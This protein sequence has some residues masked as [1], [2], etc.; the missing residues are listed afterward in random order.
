[1][2]LNE[3]IKDRV[4]AILA[5]R[6]QKARV[7]AQHRWEEITLE[8]P[9]I[10]SLKSELNQTSVRLSKIVL[11]RSANVSQALENKG[12]FSAT[13]FRA[14]FMYHDH[15]CR[16]NMRASAV[17]PDRVVSVILYSPF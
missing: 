11:S 4:Y 15:G 14:F 12:W 17:F 10:A 16:T 2:I 13:K 6:R 3:N 1:M 5:E 7:A 9:E 8:I